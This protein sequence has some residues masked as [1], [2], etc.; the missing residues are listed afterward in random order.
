MTSFVG[1]PGHQHPQYYNNVI[2]SVCN[3]S[4]NSEGLAIESPTSIRLCLMILFR[5][6]S[7]LCCLSMGD[8]FYLR[9][10]FELQ[11]VTLMQNSIA[12]RIRWWCDEAKNVVDCSYFIN[13]EGFMIATPIHWNMLMVVNHMRFLS[14]I[15]K[16]SM[17]VKLYVTV[18][19]Q[20]VYG[21]SIPSTLRIVYS[22][23]PLYGI[24]YVYWYGSPTGYPYTIIL[25]PMFNTSTVTFFLTVSKLLP[26]GSREAQLPPPPR[27]F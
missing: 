9:L 18:M 13:F 1:S 12:Y 23:G 7:Y 8:S 16:C 14:W 24:I 5:F 10:C 3:H 19:Y 25:F 6:C 27:K 11:N 21:N 4:G 2:S 17:F 20:W 15:Y 22:S 26:R